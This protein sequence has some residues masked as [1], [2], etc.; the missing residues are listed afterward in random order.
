[1]NFNDIKMNCMETITC[2]VLNVEKRMSKVNKPYYVV[3]LYD[4]SKEKI[5]AHC[6]GT[7][8]FNKY[9]II[10]ASIS[11]KDYNG[12]D[13]FSIQNCEISTSELTKED[14][15]VDEL[16]DTE[17]MYKYIVS[18]INNFKNID[19]KNLVLTIYETYKK[20]LKM[21]SA[22]K[23]MH[24]NTKGGLIYHMFRMVKSAE[25]LCDVYT[26]AN[27]ELVIAGC[28]LHD[29]GKISEL[30]TDS[31]IGDASYT[32]DGNLFGHLLIAAELITYYSKKA[33]V[34][35]KEVVRNLKHIIVSHHFNPE[36]GAIKAPLTMEAFLVSQIDYID[37]QYYVYEYATERTEPG[38][39]SATGFMNVKT[40][41]RA[42]L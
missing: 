18:V 33:K 29:I 3:Q 21:W 27:R 20:D 1:M 32:V 37:S 8:D 4:M 23:A 41:Y 22:S 31:V 13:S 7:F 19:L 5:N 24:H 30:D 28:A 17:E 9:D 38:C 10:D 6:W 14:F 11:K 35:N 25:A 26:S 34:K 12:A 16:Y 2:L 36:W 15:S 42:D 40:V 39:I